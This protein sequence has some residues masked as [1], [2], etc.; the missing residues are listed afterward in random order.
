MKR[1]GKSKISKDAVDEDDFCLVRLRPRGSETRA[2]MWQTATPARLPQSD[3]VLLLWMAR[4][5]LIPA[6]ISMIS[7]ASEATLYTVQATERSRDDTSTK[8]F[9]LLVQ[10]GE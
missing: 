4:R 7:Q 8:G 10:Q 1:D 9:M 5:E 2:P 6:V 3:L